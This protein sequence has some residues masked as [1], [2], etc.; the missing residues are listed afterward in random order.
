MHASLSS[1]LLSGGWKQLVFISRLGKAEDQGSDFLKVTGGH[2]AL[3]PLGRADV[4]P[5]AGPKPPPLPPR[6]PT[7]PEQEA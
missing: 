6:P 2:R 3:K 5:T 7:G 4:I 1:A